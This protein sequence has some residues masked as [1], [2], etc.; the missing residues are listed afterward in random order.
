MILDLAAVSYYS[1]IRFSTCS[2]LRSIYIIIHINPFHDG[3]SEAQY[4]NF[5]LAGYHLFLHIMLMLQQ[6]QIIYFKHGSKQ[7]FCVYS[8]VVLD[9]LRFL[10]AAGG[11][12]H[13]FGNETD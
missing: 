10:S 6:T 8:R 9:Y 3:I 12:N 4:H 2:A 11:A 7:S 5:L 1:A 13:G